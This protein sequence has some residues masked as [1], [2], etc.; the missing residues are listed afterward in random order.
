MFARKR[1]LE[2]EWRQAW[3][4]HGS[5]DPGEGSGGRELSDGGEAVPRVRRAHLA[6]ASS[7]GGG[8]GNS[9]HDGVLCHLLPLGSPSISRSCGPNSTVCCSFDL[10][11]RSDSNCA[12]LGVVPAPQ[13][14]TMENVAAR[15][16]ELLD[17][18][19]GCVAVR[20]APRLSFPQIFLWRLSHL[21]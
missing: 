2:F 3:R 12:G 16:P 19:G 20:G 10:R 8:R 18:V 9:A 4:G 5:P 15:V 7:G 14:I 17:Q 1:A 21:W 11:R 6:S 13:P